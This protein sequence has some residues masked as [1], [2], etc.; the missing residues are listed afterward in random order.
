[1]DET[2]KYVLNGRQIKF[3]ITSLQKVKYLMFRIPNA[4]AELL[5]VVFCAICLK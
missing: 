4:Q 2:Q 1:M 3:Y 5:T